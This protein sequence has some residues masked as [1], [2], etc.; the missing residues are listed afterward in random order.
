MTQVFIEDISIGYLKDTINESN[1]KRVFVVTGKNNGFVNSGAKTFIESALVGVEFVRFF[2]FEQNP[3]FEDAIRGV[4]LFQQST[5][6]MIIAIGGGSVMDMAKLINVFSANTHVNS[7]DIVHN[8]KL[9]T[10]AGKTMIAIPTTAGTGSEATHF[11]VVYHKSKKYSVAN[12]SMLPNIVGLNYKF[13]TSKSPYLTATTGLDAL[14]QAI[15][16]YWSVCANKESKK[17]AEEAIRLLLPNLKPAVLAP[18]I[19]NRKAVMRGAYLAGKAINSTK[20]TAAHAISYAFTTFFDIPHGHAVFLTLPYFF[21]LNSEI[22]SSNIN[23]TR[24]MVYLKETM[25]SLYK[26]LGVDTPLQAF[27]FLKSYTEA[28]G[29]ETSLNRLGINK[30]S[31]IELIIENVNLERLKNN[32]I[33]IGRTEL[34]RLWT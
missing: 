31:D 26:L 5:F 7:L 21:I 29:V 20:T 30:K 13:T 9:V 11:A 8:S 15:E 23:D 22:S 25:K 4:K 10:R 2:E 28:I 32:P 18:E 3:K 24:G 16:S 14:A 12:D 17:Y 6:D 19:N 27:E 33:K 1:C 34:Y